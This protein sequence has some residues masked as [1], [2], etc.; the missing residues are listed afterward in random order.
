MRNTRQRT[1][2]EANSAARL[3][4]HL[5]AVALP[6]CAVLLAGVLGTVGWATPK[7]L[8]I[9]GAATDGL[10]ADGAAA[11]MRR[12]I[13]KW[14]AARWSERGP[15]LPEL[16]SDAGFLR[17]ITLDL[18]G[19]IPSIDEAESFAADTNVDKRDA[20]IKRLMGQPRYFVYQAEVLRKEWLR[21]G[22]LIR[23]SQRVPALETWIRDRLREHVAYDQL[24]RDLLDAG[25]ATSGAGSAGARIF[26][27]AYSE[28]PERIA[29]QS[30]RLFLGISLECAECHDHPF[31]QWSRQQFWQ[32]AALFSDSDDS[33]S[34]SLRPSTTNAQGEAFEGHFPFS[35]QWNEHADAR[36]NVGA[37]LTDPNNP[38]FA[39]ATVNRMWKQFFGRG[40][41]E[42]ADAIVLDE[43]EPNL[44]LLDEL[45]RLFVASHFD[46]AAL[47]EGMLLSRVYQLRTGLS[48]ADE[49][50]SLE[51]GRM[52]LRS[53]SA[54]Q[55]YDSLLAATGAAELGGIESLPQARADS[56]QAARAQFV[57]QFAG[58][59][60]SPTAEP[61]VSQALAL[62]NSPLL[63]SATAVDGT[64]TLAA[65]VH[66]PFLSEAERI[67]R[68]YLAA[69]SRQ[70]TAAELEAA[71]GA[72][73]TARSE[74]ERKELL[75]DLFWSLLNSPEFT[76][77]H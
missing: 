38:Y 35:D 4:R 19:R 21:D 10:I 2:L 70:P 13:D 29:A 24:V 16:T 51:L 12:A 41:V 61:T 56:L 22:D 62:M 6:V 40:L 54:E 34:P 71:Q 74:D 69:L 30:A 15:A 33:A 39:R 49:E 52:P 25:G 64:G 44:P 68:L 47:T 59:G 72:V 43:S 3:F 5:A 67:E 45:A 42:P 60:N 36:A 17:R 76:F 75:G 14:Y 27:D 11:D 58:T 18:E 55:M 77:N 46:H 7:T 1:R 28:Q 48:G 57:E 53:L 9:G 66:S 20:I 73:A 37:W 8:T 63:L 50:A 31:Q 65:V 23:V 32:Y 26:R